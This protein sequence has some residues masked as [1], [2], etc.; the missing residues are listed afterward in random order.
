[1]VI[2]ISI[3]ISLCVAI[4]TAFTGLWAKNINEH[5]RE[6]KADLLALNAALTTIRETLQHTR[7]NYVTKEDFG[8]A[9]S[10][11]T[12]QLDRMEAKLDDKRAIVDCNVRHG[13]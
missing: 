6:T 1:M 2:E 9:M 4:V 8:H 11:I 10:R 13:V 5:K 3:I 12:A 7:E